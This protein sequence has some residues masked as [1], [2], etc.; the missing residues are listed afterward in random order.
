M[1]HL[2]QASCKHRPP[3]RVPVIGDS[4]LRQARLATRGFNTDVN[5][6]PTTRSNLDPRSAGRQPEPV[7]NRQHDYYK[8]GST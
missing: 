6:Q 1:Q 2:A 7:Y 3:V 4:F 5:N 8:S